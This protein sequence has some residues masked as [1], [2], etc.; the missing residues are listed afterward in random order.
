MN[1][2]MKGIT[3]CA[4][5]AYYNMKKHRCTRSATD[6]GDAR[7]HFY[8]DCPLPDVTPVESQPPRVISKDELWNL[9]GGSVV[10]MEE[11]TI[12]EEYPEPVIPVCFEDIQDVTIGNNPKV[13]SAI[14]FNGRYDRM[15]QYDTMYRFWTARPT[16]EQRREE[17]WE[18]QMT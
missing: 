4:D 10:W 1:L 17:K 6:E 8:A 12:I 7:S 18:E 3:C 9:P 2:L 13:H 11:R 16:E 5:C 14:A 15:D